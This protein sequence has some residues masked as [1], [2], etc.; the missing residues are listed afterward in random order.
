MTR[1]LVTGATGFIGGRFAELAVRREWEVVG[2][3]RTWSRAARLARLPVDIV[4]GDVLD[5]DSLIRAMEGCDAVVHCAVDNS[6]AGK[7]H[8]DIGVRGTRNVM[9]AAAAS[10]VR[11]VVHI[12]SAAVFGYSPTGHIDETTPVT[13]QGDYYCDGKIDAEQ[14]A[15]DAA[16]SGV[17]VAILRP[18]IVYGPFGAYSRDIVEL[19]RHGRLKLVDGATGTCNALY[20]DNLVDAIFATI[21]TP[22]AIGE[23][24]HVSDAEVVTWAHYLETHAQAAGPPGPLPSITLE[25]LKADRAAE[26]VSP[27]LAT[28]RLAGDPRVRRRARRVR[29]IDAIAKFLMRVARFILPSAALTRLGA[30]IEGDNSHEHRPAAL[31]VGE[32]LMISAFQDVTYGIDKARHLLG[33]D[34]KIDFA[35]GMHRTGEWIRWARL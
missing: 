27:L 2:F 5:K 34:P 29:A 14:E 8:R 33:Y 13:H 32:E 19:H 21:A 23:I 24:I 3:V 26:K 15:L 31:D 30:M 11:S 6:K 16:R 18:T 35:E 1:V 28:I 17:P 22:A 9:E 7:A 4:Q 12:S 10:G 25:Q 20:V